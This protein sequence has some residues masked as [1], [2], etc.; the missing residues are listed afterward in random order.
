MALKLHKKRWYPLVF[1]L[2]SIGVVAAWFVFVAER[3]PEL[4]LS[5]IAAIAGFT[6]FLY[7]QHLD[8]TRLFKELF[9][10]FNARY[11]KL[12]DGLNKVLFGPRE[13]NLSDSERKLLFSYFNLCA[14]EYIF[15]QAGY[16]DH[17]VWQSWQRGM[18]VFFEH[19]RIS[20]LWASECQADSYYGFHP[21]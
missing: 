4:L 17:H 20:C 9:V 13:G 18:R 3:R 14:E 11:D 15:Y 16:I 1:L 10:E 5:G 21:D 7:R 2:G 12:S 6:Y 8:E 19:P